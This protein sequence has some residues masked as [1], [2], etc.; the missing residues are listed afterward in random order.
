M[1]W[2]VETTLELVGSAVY[3]A[4][5]VLAGLRGKQDA[6]AR[7][8][9]LL[10]LDLFAYTSLSLVSSLT[11]APDWRW[12]ERAAA[13]LAAPLGLHLVLAFVG[14]RRALRAF[15]AVTY[16]YFVAVAVACLVALAMPAIVSSGAWARAMLLGMGPAFAVGTFMVGRHVRREPDPE[17]RLRTYLIIGAVGL[18]VGGATTDLVSLAG[19][20]AMPRLAAVGLMLSA[21]VLSVAVLR[22]RLIEQRGRLALLNASVVAILGVVAQIA[23]FT[24]VGAHLAFLALGT[25]LVFLTV[26]VAVRPVLTAYATQRERT[27]YLVTL[28]RLSSQMAHDIRNPLAAIRGAAQFLEREGR[29]GRTD[30]EMLALI[31]AQVDRLETVVADYRRY[32]RVEPDP[33]SVELNSLVESSLR[34][35]EASLAAEPRIDVVRELA[36][37]LPRCRADPDLVSGALENLVRNAREAM[38]TGGR[39]T[40]STALVRDGARPRV[41]VRVRDTGVGM[42]A[43]AR[44]RAFESFFSTKEEGTGLGLPFVR[45]VAEVHRGDVRLSSRLGEGTCVDLEIAV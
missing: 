26:L 6:L 14:A 22:V 35:C 12:R 9:A 4:L 29:E 25:V 7:V 44:E 42:D 30:P 28:G 41:C 1:D 36:R 38:P 39:L 43:R 33:R 45:R 31:V 2:N 20:S 32:G 3:L 5:A 27:A 10:C 19:A 16:L 40:V 17:E 21:L 24:L 15:L 8:L 23:L 37:D 34:A 11:D 13:A 18:G